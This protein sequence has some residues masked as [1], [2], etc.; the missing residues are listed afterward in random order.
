MS[1]GKSLVNL[2]HRNRWLLFSSV[3]QQDSNYVPDPA[4]QLNPY[5][6]QDKSFNNSFFKKAERLTRNKNVD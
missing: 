2:S 1:I 6:D 5:L 3:V 4:R